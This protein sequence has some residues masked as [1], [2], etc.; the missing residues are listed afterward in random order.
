ML[1]RIKE[2][3]IKA[4]GGSCDVLSVR[5]YN[6]IS[7]HVLYKSSRQGYVVH[8]VNVSFG[9]LH[10]GSYCKDN[11]EEAEAIFLERAYNIKREGK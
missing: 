5:K 3:V 1:D 7:Y 10:N 11:L 2:E 4:F 9:G 6:D 8:L